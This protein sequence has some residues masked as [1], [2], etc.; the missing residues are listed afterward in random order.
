MTLQRQLS[1]PTACS[2]QYFLASL[3]TQLHWCNPT[4]LLTHSLP[5]G[6]SAQP[7]I[8]C[9]RMKEVRKIPRNSPPPWGRRMWCPGPNTRGSV[10]SLPGERGP[11]GTGRSPGSSPGV[12]RMSHFSQREMQPGI[13]GK[14]SWCHGGHPYRQQ[15]LPSWWPRTHGTKPGRKS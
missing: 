12:F 10:T 5:P 4:A 8:V 1:I 14:G 9:S 7:Q 3:R 15:E 13:L 6:S 11:G 2:Q